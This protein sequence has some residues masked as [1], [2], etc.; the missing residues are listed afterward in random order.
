MHS[1]IKENIKVSD[2]F[3]QK[4]AELYISYRTE[5]VTATKT[6]S[7][8]FLFKT[9]GFNT[10]ELEK[11]IQKN[12]IA[13]DKKRDAGQTPEILNDIYRSDLGELLMTYY[14]EEKL[15]EKERFRIPLKNIS[16]R[17]LSNMPGRGMDAIGYRVEASKVN[18]LVGEAKVSESPK[19]PPSVVDESSDSIYKTQLA[20]KENKS[21]ILEKLA[22]YWRRLSLDDASVI[23]LAIWAIENDLFDHYDITFGC[24][25]IRDYKCVKE[26]TDYGKLKTDSKAF[27][28]FRIAFALLSFENKSIAETVD[29]FYSKVQELIAK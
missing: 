27:E 14:F 5:S 1:F 22:D 24:T 23:G 20:K 8:N 28:K 21:L 2:A 9:T 11:L 25:L 18:L 26:A 6:L 15:N 4:F 13:E 17:E 3:I 12:V 7:T 19:S 29:L 10:D 16:F